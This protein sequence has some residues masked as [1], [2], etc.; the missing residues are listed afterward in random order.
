MADS[1]YVALVHAEIDGELDGRQRAELAR[2]LLADPEARALRE[3][4]VRLRTLLAT[5]EEV[6]PP[7]H[8]R[9]R[10]LQALPVSAS[11]RSHFRW[12][13]QHWRYAA[14]IAAALGAGA[15][16]Y[17]TV[18]GPGPASTEM[19]GTIAAKRPP[20]TLDTVTL[21]AGPVTGRVSL[22]RDGGGL[23]LAF[24]LAASAPVDVLIGSAGHSLRVDGLAQ[25]GSADQRTTVALPKSETGGRRTVDLT[26]LMS[27][28]E[29]GRATLTAPEG[30]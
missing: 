8:V 13:A 15:L 7:G 12:P 10:I 17:E 20:V 27:G 23:G 24:D 19:A 16:V 25:S 2:R 9:A 18:D 5:I 14:F 6:E 29:V 4:L 26:F 3:D 11:P 22:Y 1:E 21:G 28:R 30:H